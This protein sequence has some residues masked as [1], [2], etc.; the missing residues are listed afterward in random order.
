M[1]TKKSATTKQTETVETT[2]VAEEVTPVE[3]TEQERPEGVQAMRAL[4]RAAGFKKC[5]TRDHY[6]NRL[7]DEFR[8][9]VEGQTDPAIRPLDEFSGHIAACKQCSKIRAQDKRNITR[10]A[11]GKPVNGVARLA[12]LLQKRAEI[13]AAIAT[14]RATLNESEQNAARAMYQAAQEQE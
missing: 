9:P 8:K 3:Q 2:E 5:P 7:P 14:L 1:A 4:L 13:D 6:M 12:K 10:E 11:S